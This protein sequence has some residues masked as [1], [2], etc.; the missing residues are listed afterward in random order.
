MKTFKGIVIGIIIFYLSMVANLYYLDY[1]FNTDP[2]NF[3][4]NCPSIDSSNFRFISYPSEINY[5]INFYPTSASGGTC[6]DKKY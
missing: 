6:T 1:K 2:R 4:E 3:G 5:F